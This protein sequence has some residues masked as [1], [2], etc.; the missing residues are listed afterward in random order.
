MYLAL[1]CKL[2]LTVFN[3]ALG[4]LSS[5]VKSCSHK[6]RSWNQP[7]LSDEKGFCF[8]EQRGLHDGVPTHD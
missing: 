8:K 7:V 4:C 1:R 6:L 2:F 5:T 3:K